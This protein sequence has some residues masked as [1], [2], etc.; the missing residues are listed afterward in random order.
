[1]AYIKKIEKVQMRATKILECTKHLKYPDRLRLLN[2]P[3]LY[4]RRLRGDM[5]CVFKIVTG[6]IDRTVACTF[7]NSHSVTRGNRF[8]LN[9]RHVHY[10]LTKFSFTNRVVSIW[11]SL[12]DYVVAAS[13][14]AHFEKQLDFFWKDQDCMYNWK[15][16]LS[17]IGNR[18][19]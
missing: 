18:S 3:T 13:S 19:F 2:L 12:P 8:K 5:I 6:I 1:M 4:Y 7:I 9:Q 14:V 11:N 16:S 10:N 17:G 15:A